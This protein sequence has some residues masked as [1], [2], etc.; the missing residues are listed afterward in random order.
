MATEFQHVG[1]GDVKVGKDNTDDGKVTPHPPARKEDRQSPHT[2][3]PNTHTC[4][5]MHTAPPTL[6]A[7]F[8]APCPAP[9]SWRK[10]SPG[11]LWV[12]WSGTR[13]CC[14]RT[15]NT[16]SRGAVEGNS[17]TSAGVHLLSVPVLALTC[18]FKNWL[19]I[20]GLRMSTF[21]RD[22]TQADDSLEEA[23]APHTVNHPTLGQETRAGDQG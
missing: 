21:K 9:V 16:A 11:P 20:S 5:R 4:A 8:A 18:P 23:W 13:P 17:L 15:G 19:Y 14:G 7:A 3:V 10:G 12:P 6:P 22:R 1:V 2:E